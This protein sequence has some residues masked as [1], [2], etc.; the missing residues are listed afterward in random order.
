MPRKRHPVSTFS[1]IKN[2]FYFW[3]DLILTL[4]SIFA[5]FSGNGNILILA[6]LAGV[7]PVFWSATKALL[8]K[9]LTI[10]LL[11]A[12]ALIFSLFNKEFKS[13]V[14]ISLMLVSARFLALLTENRTKNAIQS[15]LKLKPEK[16]LVKS[17][18]GVAEKPVSELK[19]GD[20]IIVGPGERIAVDGVVAEGIATVDQSSLTGES[21][22]I[23]KKAGD[24]VFSSTLNITGSLIVR[25]TKIGEDTTFSKILKLI[26]ESQKGKAPIY[27][28]IDKFVSIYIFLTF[29]I[30]A[31]LFFVTR[32][33]T[34]ILAVLLVTCA[35]DLAIAIPLAFIVTI[36][37]A[38]KKGIII[39]GAGFV[40]NLTKIKL[41]IFDK[42]GTI[43]EGKPGI[44]NIFCFKEYE[45]ERV[46][47][48]L[49]GLVVESNHPT[50][51]AIYKYIKSKNIEI[52][53]IQKINEEVGY[54]LKG[55]FRGKRALSGN[56]RY[57][58]K[59]GINFTS[60]QILKIQKEKSLGRMLVGLAV[61]DS[62]VGL[63]SLSDT[64]RPNVR[65]VILQL[66][67][68][69]IERMVILTG[70]NEVVA[71]EVAQ[72]VGIN[73][74]QANLL[75]QDKVNFIKNSINKNFKVAMVGDGVNDAAS[76][77]LADVGFA[78]GAIG[79]DA[80]IEAADVA[81]MKDNLKNMSE[82]IRMSRRTI[83]IV[84][85]N[86]FLW[87]VINLIGLVLVFAG[88]LPPVSAAAYNFLTDFL[89]PL[90]S[91]RLL[92]SSKFK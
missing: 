29:L 54:G 39:K 30:S 34:L 26:E 48:I 18:K 76:L 16:V 91:F 51:K 85:Q 20:L 27:S 73:E 43:T 38:A 47:S 55:F 92:R 88:I 35:D 33:L 58:K 37:T 82:A 6:A 61:G 23:V 46:L 74:F 12:A 22:A 2:P 21:M 36:G 77:A 7:F 78:M 52:A 5:I 28:S 40:E 14:F 79:S 15:L 10:D 70:D 81:L 53:N 3:F 9:K 60:D 56:L 63:L 44:K 50:D 68:L 65:N 41:L 49:G 57:L 89:P 59:K 31:I 71:K 83:K 84:N 64:I 90:N 69:G 62:L 8:E 24:E 72:E 80:A 75:P 19:L 17:D 42:T 13:A 1:L 87:G 4:F 45:R 66:K 11:A 32:D 67:K 25:T 86:L